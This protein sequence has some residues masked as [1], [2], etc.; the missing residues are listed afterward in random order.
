[1]LRTLR[2]SGLLIAGLISMAHAADMDVR[3]TTSD[4][5]TKMVIQNASA[6]EVSSITSLGDGFFRYVKARHLIGG[7]VTPTIGATTS[8]GTATPTV[9]GTD[10]AGEIVIA[11]G[12][13]AI[14]GLTVTVTFNSPY[15]TAPYVVL[16]PSNATAAGLATQLLPVSLFVTSTTNTFVVTAT[17]LG[18]LV[19]G[20]TFRWHYHV[21]Q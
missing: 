17:G 12:G 9:T 5:S 2:F 14:T 7:G 15:A 8:A 16:T 6:V 10:A 19:A 13:G 18:S 1:M 11:T 21:I 4:G 20:S 3:L